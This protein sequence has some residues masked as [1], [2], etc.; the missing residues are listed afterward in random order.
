MRAVA[1]ICNKTNSIA[2]AVVGALA[3]E[4]GTICFY[5]VA[6]WFVRNVCEKVKPMHIFIRTYINKVTD[7]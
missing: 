6:N 5:N 7:T 4:S 3:I 1:L 2:S